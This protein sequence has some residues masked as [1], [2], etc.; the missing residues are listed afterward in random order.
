MNSVLFILNLTLSVKRFDE[1]AAT[2]KKNLQLTDSVRPMLRLFSG[3]KV[4]N[5]FS[6]SLSSIHMEGVEISSLYH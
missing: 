6:I 5:D 1:V 2:S 3:S 4:S